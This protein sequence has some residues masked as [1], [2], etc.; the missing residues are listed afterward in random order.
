MKQYLLNLVFSFDQ[1]LSAILGGHPDETLSQRLGRAHLAGVLWTEP[2]RFVVD[3]LFYLIEGLPDHCL[4]SLSGD[5]GV[6]EI[7]NW[8]GSRDDIKVKEN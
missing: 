3:L 4:R 2:M 5:S 8:G 7:W 1:L 6:R